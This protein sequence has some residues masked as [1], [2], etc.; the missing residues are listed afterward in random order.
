MSD[1]QGKYNKLDQMIKVKADSLYLK[2]EK[3]F[4][5]YDEKKLLSTLFIVLLVTVLASIFFTVNLVVIHFSPAG[6]INEIHNYIEGFAHLLSGKGNENGMNIMVCRSFIIA[7][8]GAALS[9]S[10]AV[11]QGVFRNPMASPG[12][13]G[14]QSGGIL[15]GAIY[16]LLFTE[17]N[18]TTQIFNGDGLSDYIGGLSLLDR[19]A[20]QAVILL[21]AFMT[22]M[23][24]VWIARAAGRGKV[25]ALMLLMVGSVLSA[26]IQSLITMIRY[27]MVMLDPTDSRISSLQIFMMGSFNDSY[28]P[29]HLLLIAVPV[30]ICLIILYRM[31][32]KINVL[33]FGEEEAKT[34]GIRVSLIQG[35][36]IVLSTV[37]T[38]VTVSFCG[39][40][41]FIGMM[42]PHIARLF[43]GPDYKN[44][45]PVS[46]LLGS[47]F[48][49][50][51]YD[52]SSMLNMA[53]YVNLYSSL[54]GGIFFLVFMIRS[55]RRRSA[56]WA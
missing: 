54:I 40:I 5:G 46:A 29:E 47:V 36:L 14:A 20:R 30:G 24:V 2:E 18:K 16:I 48:L 39:Q 51:I 33:V 12:T 7:L 1:K 11:F 50:I 17:D 56:E 38:A 26:F 31:R 35:V 53:V 52:I 55:R 27:Y 44:L 37:M 15:A 10:G 22:V 8:V 21:G 45:I 9:V 25:S 19:Y 6:Y 34:M 3:R 49:L 41:G 23:F 13:I 32:M 42:V 28:S 4:I 43:S